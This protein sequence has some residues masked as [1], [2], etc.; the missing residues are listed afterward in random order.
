MGRV[1]RL[2]LP[3][4]TAALVTALILPAGASARSSYCSTSGDI[5]YGR[6]PGSSPVKLRISL[7]AKYFSRYR[8][9]ITGPHGERDCKRFRVH[10]TINGLY[11]STVS[12]PK[13]F[14]YRGKGTYKARWYAQG[15]ALGPAI[16]F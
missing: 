7:A 15:T 8:L 16:S 6:V 2:S 13:N 14:P 9:C 10:R 3:L 4:A 11:R 5:C 12:W 1:K